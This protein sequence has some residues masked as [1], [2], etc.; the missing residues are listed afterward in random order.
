MI[1]FF[2]K[3]SLKRI[4]MIRQYVV[5]LVLSLYSINAFCVEGITAINIG[6]SIMQNNDLINSGSK[7]NWTF[8][9][10]SGVSVTLKSLQ[11]IDGKTGTQGNVMS[12]NETVANGNSVSYSTTIGLLGIHIPVTCRFR[13]DFNGTEYYVDAVYSG[14]TFSLGNTLKISSTGNGTVSY[15]GTI[16]RNNFQS[17][18]VERMGS[19]T[20]EFTPDNGYRIKSVTVNGT[21]VTS[22]VYNDQYT[23]NLITSDLTVE[24]VFEAQPATITYNLSIKAS[25]NG[26]ASYDGT[27]IRY[28]TKLF[29]C[30]EN[31]SVHITFMPD[32]GYRIKN[33][34]VDGS[35]FTISGNQYTISNINKNTTVEVEFEAIPPATYTISVSSIGQGYLSYNNGT[36]T[37]RSG[38]SSFTANEGTDAI[39]TFSPD[40]GYQIKSVKINGLKVSV[41]SNQYTVSNIHSNTTVDV[42]FEAIPQ[43]TYTLSISSTG[44]GAVSYSGTTVRNNI[45]PVS[46]IEGTNAT[47]TFTPDNGNRIKSIKVDGSDVTENVGGSTY[48]ITNVR[49]NTMVDVAFEEEV[50]TFSADGRNYNVLSYDEK[51]VSVAKGN[52]GH[53]IEVPETVDYQGTIWRV[54]GIDSSIVDGELAAMIW[55]PQQAC[56]LNTRNPNF[57]L[58]VNSAAYAPASVGNVIVNNTAER[59]VLTDAAD[60]YGFCCPREFTAKDISYT[61]HYKMQTGIGEAKGWETIALPFDVQT[62]SHLQMGEIVPFANKTAGDSRKPFWL[63]ELTNSGWSGA[64]N[65]KANTPYI[66]S[67]PNHENYKQ[68]FRLQGDVTFSST[69][70]T[71]RR[72]DDLQSPTFG[73]KTFSPSYTTKNNTQFY[74]LNVEN[75][76]ISYNGESAKGS[77]F[78]KGLRAV[79]PFEAYMTSTSGTRWIAIDDDMT[80]YINEVT[81]LLNDEKKYVRIY[82]IN[83]QLIKLATEENINLPA[84]IYII[85]GQKLYIK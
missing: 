7:L 47:I 84:G 31:T 29:K 13:Y 63:M 56:S 75:N 21:D 33:V 32:N 24:V 16:I 66:I 65:I 6:G 17:F 46:I 20:I 70:V 85:N 48:T 57:L 45:I 53:W 74:A 61:H 26:S 83:G 64:S 54:T 69:N 60:G 9:N 41:S 10:N 36:T 76:H 67:M 22:K 59:I 5:L 49:N 82:N 18:D 35:T 28:S 72:T 39:I 58:Y 25:G 55:N 15:K 40:N 78:V 77:R 8:S 71:V 1:N 68:E 19:A 80:T 14:S 44:N 50:K 3:I 12:V 23:S 30:E 42:E 38:K 11:L 4:S 62:V 79:R 2:D 43:A 81:E 52:Y 73:D 37:L 34:K 51:T 27:T